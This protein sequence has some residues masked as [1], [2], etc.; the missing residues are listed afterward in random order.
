[1][2]R[3]STISILAAIAVIAVLASGCLVL[4]RLYS[5]KAKEVQQLQGQLTKMSKREKQ[6]I[7]M[8][9]VNSQMEEIADQERRI[10]D[11]QR[12]KAEQQREVADEMRRH[13][14]QERQKALEAEHRAI[15]ASN[16]ARFQRGVAE[17]QR[18]K[19]EQSKRQAD[20]LFYISQARSLGS[21][22][23]TQYNAGNHDIANLLAYSAYLFTTRYGGDLYHQDVYQPLV[24]T[25]KSQYEWN[26]HKGAVT[27]VAFT[28]ND[29][30]SLISASTY[31]ELMEH[32]LKGDKL[33]T[34]SIFT[35][36]QYDFRDIYIERQKGIIYAVSR[37]GHLLVMNKSSQQTF[38]IDKIGPLLGLE[39]LD[40]HMLLFGER[41]LALFDTQG[42]TIL[43]TKVLPYQLQKVWVYAGK[44]LL[45]DKQGGMHF[46][47]SIDQITD[48][49]APVSGQITAFASSKESGLK[50]YGTQDGTLWLEYKD[51]HMQKLLG[52]RSRI[53]KIK[54]VGWQVYT[55][56]YDGTLRL[57][58]ADHLK[59]EPMTIIK[60]RRWIMNFTFDDEKND[61]WVC[62]QGGYLTKAFI[63]V[64]LMGQR[65]KSMLTRN[66]TRNEWNYYMGKRIPY[67]E[68]IGKEVKP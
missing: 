54:I 48:R 18:A 41:G 37:T 8:Q 13:A 25:S 42:K 34:K 68:F 40:N 9:R 65:L 51:G 11:E 43:K 6:S 46:L 16:V 15:E 58:L 20:T 61:I 22:A 52:H 7:V 57:W 14:E 63:A 3:I 24:L 64:P 33:V 23:I 21:T 47:Q 1:M 29:R 53:S 32:Q 62:D 30:Y 49:R 19:A 56:S 10:S 5:Q 12:E 38:S 4:Y 66:L 36:S 55:A 45:F 39:P 60:T 2:K 26:V 31:G 59:I 67:E 27:D 44:P 28:T 50:A 35:N 17:R